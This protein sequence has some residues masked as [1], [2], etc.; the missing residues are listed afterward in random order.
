[1]LKH[2][3]VDAG[4]RHSMQKCG[5]VASPEREEALHKAQVSEYGLECIQ[6][7]SDRYSAHEI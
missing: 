6:T 2:C 5:G 1:M 3:K 4:V 7:Q